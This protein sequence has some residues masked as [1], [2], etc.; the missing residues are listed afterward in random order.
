LQKIVSFKFRENR[1]DVSQKYVCVQ[2]LGLPTPVARAMLCEELKDPIYSATI[3]RKLA[4]VHSLDVPINK[5][6][7][8]LFDTLNQWLETVRNPQ[9]SDKTAAQTSKNPELEQ[10]L[11]SFDFESELKWLKQF[12]G[13]CNSPVVFSHNDLQ[14]GNILLPESAS[15]KMCPF[16][17]R[18]V[19]IDFEFCAYNYRGFD[20]GNHFCERMFDYSNPEW[21]HFFVYTDAYPDDCAKRHFLREY[22]KQSK[23]HKNAINDTEDQL[24]KEA[25]YYTL[26]SHFLW[27]LWSINNARNSKI[28]FG[29]LEYGKTRL[30][31]YVNHKDQLLR[32]FSDQNLNNV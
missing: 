5:E 20:L 1:D 25:N 32:K 17:D 3:A 14:E 7:T 16:D 10:E 12:L 30:T 13:S 11:C 19:F 15:I 2:S 18:I 24:I 9:T 27:T 28:Q 6:P 26:A 22:L 23:E 8:W 4:T 21:P 31:A 29:Y